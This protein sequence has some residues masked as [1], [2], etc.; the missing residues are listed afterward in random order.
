MNLRDAPN[1]LRPDPGKHWVIP[2]NLGK[3]PRI[4]ASLQV[5]LLGSGRKMEEKCRGIA[6]YRKHL[7]D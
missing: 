6:I 5:S 1:G 4:L 3:I 7:L 2:T